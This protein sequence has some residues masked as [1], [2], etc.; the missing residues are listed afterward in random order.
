MLVQ[1]WKRVVAISLSFWMQ[2]L[3]LVVLIAPEIYYAS[4]GVDTNPQILWWSGILLLLGGLLGRLFQQ[5]NSLV[6]EWLRLGGVAVVLFL[7][8][9][10]LGTSVKADEAATLKIAVPFIAEKEGVRTKAYLD[11]VGV[12]T[13]CFGS[14][15]GIRLGMQKTYSEC[16][17]LLRSEVAEYRHGLHKYFTSV[18]K[19]HRLTP[20]RDTAYTSLAFNCG[21]RAIGRSTATR[22]LNNGDI[23]G[24]CQA[25]G[26][27]NKAGGRVIRGLVLRRAEERA[28]CLKGIR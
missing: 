12:P 7:A 13:I 21:I 18:T 16:L 27:W 19:Q 28:L 3:G 8:A 22:R 4:T 11:I 25:I 10:L 2:V 23:K 15:R 5:G 14:T 6:R 17:S 20:E 26:W 9:V 1:D 24:G